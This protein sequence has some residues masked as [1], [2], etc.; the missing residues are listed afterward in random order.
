MGAKV[1][2]CGLSTGEALAAALDSGA[3]FVGFVFYPRSPRHVSL[4]R[5]AA[6]AAMAKGRAK[7]VA[8]TV[9]ADDGLISD[10]AAMVQPDFYQ[11]H[12]AE[13]PSRVMALRAAT[14]KPVIKAAKIRDAADIAAAGAFS[15]AATLLLYD[16]KPPDSLSGALPG[17][18]GVAF[19][20]RL[21]KPT[22]G[23]DFI[24]SGGLT[25]DNVAEGIRLTGAAIVDVSSGVEC[26][27][28]VK[29][30]ALIRKFIEA[31]K[32]AR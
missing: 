30:V 6:L 17:G 21:L 15:E 26:A 10:I 24:L 13:T 19:D 18:N 9:D 8:L 32:A 2:I 1:K 29:E 22:N 25:P 12:G 7:T 3:D 31:A 27:P 20:W 14:G 16:A 23:K 4:E 5:A 11:A 28:G